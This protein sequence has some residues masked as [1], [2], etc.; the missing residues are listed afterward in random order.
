MIFTPG[1][2]LTITGTAT[3]NRGVAGVKVEFVDVT[4]AVAKTVDATLTP[5]GGTS[6]TWTASGAGLAPGIYTVRATASDA[7]GNKSAT[8]MITIVN[9]TV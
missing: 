5:P 6:V 4:S 3:D 1:S 8:A 2:T 9:L 7:A